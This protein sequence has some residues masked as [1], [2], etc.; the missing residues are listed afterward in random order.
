MPALSDTLLA[1]GAASHIEA[2]HGEPVFILSGPDAG[3]TFLAVRENAS[4]VVLDE[5]LSPDP[6][7]KRLI[8]FREGAP[9]GV[10]RLSSQDRVQTCDGKQWYAVKYPQDGY[11]SSDFELVEIVNGKDQV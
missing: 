5:N 3:K 8:R 7:A 2:V 4:D 11:L 6:R 1:A 9:Q 10:P